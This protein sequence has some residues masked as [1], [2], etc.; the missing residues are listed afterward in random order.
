MCQQPSE[1]EHAEAQNTLGFMY[2]KGQDV[3]Q[4]YKAAVQWFSKAAQQGDVSAQTILESHL[5]RK[6]ENK[7]V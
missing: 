1:Q 7:Y 5:I 3:A 4:D 6:R 2:E